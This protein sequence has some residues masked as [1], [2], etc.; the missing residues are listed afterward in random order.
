MTGSYS[1]WK[2]LHIFGVV[3]LLGNI[4]V[5]DFAFTAV[6]VVLLVV[7]GD[8]LAY[9]YF[10]DSWHIPWIAWG[11]I[12]IITSGVIWI[13][14]LIP[15]QIRQARL[16]HAFADGGSIPAAYWKLARIWTI[17]GIIAPVIPMGAVVLM[18]AKPS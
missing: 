10:A 9:N 1:V 18:V 15:V 13:A 11:R 2:V 7:A 3:L 8:T 17:M 12:L 6:G 16:A 14:V 4:I 5:T